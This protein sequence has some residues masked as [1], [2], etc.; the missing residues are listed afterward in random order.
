M[1]MICER[2]DI[3]RKSL[4]HVSADYTRAHRIN[5]P[6]PGSIDIDFS[7][8]IFDKALIAP[9]TQKKKLQMSKHIQVIHKNPNIINL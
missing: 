2:H 3:E 8:R 1:K 7:C 4:R 6:S 9:A 5:P